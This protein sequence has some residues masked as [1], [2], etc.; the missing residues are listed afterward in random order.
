MV[1]EEKDTSHVEENSAYL[2]HQIRRY[3]HRTHSPQ[4][5]SGN[6]KV[7]SADPKRGTMLLGMSRAYFRG[8]SQEAEEPVEVGLEFFDPV[9]ASG[10]EEDPEPAGGLGE[11]VDLIE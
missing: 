6:G 8:C 10:M 11:V 3:V 9:G 5:I 2:N 1:R 4:A 7:R